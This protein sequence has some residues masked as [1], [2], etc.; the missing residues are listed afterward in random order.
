MLDK[1][2]DFL[3]RFYKDALPFVIIEQWN[4][5]IQLYLLEV[6]DIVYQYYS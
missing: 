2:I 5:G 6:A 4:A 3:V 1:L